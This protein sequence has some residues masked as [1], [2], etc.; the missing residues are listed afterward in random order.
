MQ[1]VPAM[2]ACVQLMFNAQVAQGK[3]A[4]SSKAVSIMLA[5]VV[6]EQQ[7]LTQIELMCK[8]IADS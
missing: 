6:A 3:P 8:T 5:Q 7:A 1:L 2:N 4:S